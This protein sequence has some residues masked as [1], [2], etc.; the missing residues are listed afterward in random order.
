MA[1]TGQISLGQV[2]HVT[3]EVKTDMAEFIVETSA[4]NIELISVDAGTQQTRPATTTFTVKDDQ[5]RVLADAVPINQYRQLKLGPYPHG[6]GPRMAGLVLDTPLF[7]TG[8]VQ[9]TVVY[10]KL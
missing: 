2:C 3:D 4:Q 10:R 6:G 5:S 9:Y 1:I 7:G 8:P